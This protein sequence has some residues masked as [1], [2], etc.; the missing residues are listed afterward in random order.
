MQPKLSTATL[1][2]DELSFGASPVGVV[3]RIVRNAE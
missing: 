1:D 3:E 2:D